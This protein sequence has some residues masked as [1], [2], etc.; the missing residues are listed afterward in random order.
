MGLLFKVLASLTRGFLSL[1][2]REVKKQLRNSCT[3]MC[4][5]INIVYFLNVIQ[6]CVLYRAQRY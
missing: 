2:L 1:C 3:V 5:L 6:V 4:V